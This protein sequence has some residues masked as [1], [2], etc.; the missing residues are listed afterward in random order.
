MLISLDNLSVVTALSAIFAVVT[1]LSAIVADTLSN[2][3]PSPSN[4]VAVTI[5]VVFMLT[6][7][8]ICVVPIAPFAILE[9][10]TAPAPSFGVSTALSAIFAVVTELSAIVADTLSNKLPSPSNAVAVTIPVVFML[11]S[12]AILGVITEPAA[13]LVDVIVSFPILAPVTA[14]SAIFAVVTELSAIV[15]DTLSNRLPSP[16]NAEAVTIPVV[17]MLIS[18]AILGVITEPAANLV[19]VIVSFPI[20]APV[21]ALSAIFAV[22]TELSAIVA[23]TLSNRLPSP[24]NAVAVTIP[25]VLMLISFAI[26]GVITEPAANLV[27][28]I[29]SFPILAPVTALSAIFA[30]VTEL[31]AIVAD[32][33]SNRLPSPSNAVAVTIPV[34]LMLISFAILGVITEPAANL[35]DVIVSFPILAPVTA[36]SAIFAVVTELSAIVADTL[37][38]RLPSP[39]NAV[40]VTIPVVLMLISFAILG[41]ITEPAANLVDV[42][43][44]FPILAPVTALSAIFAVVTELSAIVADTLSNRLPSP[45]NAVAVTIPV[46]LMLISFAI[47]GVITEPA[48]NLVDVI[49]SFPILAPVT[50]LSAIFAV[51]TELSAIVADTLS[52]R[53]PSPSNAVAVTI[54]VVLMLI[55]F[56]ILGVI[57]EPAANLVDV[58]VSFPILAPVTALSAIFAVVTELSAIVADTLS[59]RLPSPSNAVAVTIPV[60]LMLISFAILGV[61]TE[62]AANLVDVIVSFPILAPVTALS[63]IFAVVTELSAIVADTLSNRLPSPSNAVA[64]TIP[65]VLM[66]ISFAILGVITEP[67]ANL[68][69]V[70]VSFPILA[71]VT[72]LS[73]IFAVVT[74]LSAIV[75]DTLSNRLPSPSNAV[76]VTIPVVLMLIS[77]AILGVITEP[78][79]N[80]VD[81]IVS[82]PILAPV[83]ALSAIF[84]VVTELSAIVADTLS[85]RLPSPSNAVAVTIPVV[86][87]LISFA[88]L[89]VITEPAANLVDVI[90]SFPIL[91]PVTALSAIFAV[92]TELSAIVADTL[93]NRLPSP[94]NAVAVTIPVVLMLISFAI[95]GVITEPAANLVDVIVS[96]PILAPVTALSAIFAVVTEL[97]AIVADTLSNRL[98]S[99]S[100][101]VAVTI[102][103]VLMLISFAIL[104]VITEPAANLVDV[105]V[106][107]P[108]LAPVT[109]LSA[110]FAVVTELSAIVADT[111]SNRLPSPSNAVA[112]TIPVVLMLISFAILGVITEP[113]ANLVDV[114]VSFPILAPVTALSAIFAVVTELSAIVADTLSNRL[115]SPSNAVAVT[116][117]VVLMLISFAILGV[118][119]EPAANLVDVIVS[120][121]ILAPVTAL[122]AI[123]AVVTELSAIV[124]DTLSNRLPS[125]SNA[126]AVTI[127]V[128]LM[129]ISF[130][131][132]GVITEPAANLVDVIVSFPILAPVTALS[133]IFA[134]VTELSAIV[135]DTL[136]N[137]L[138]SPSNAVAVTIPVVLM[139]I[140]FA[141]LGVITEP[142]A[143]LVDVIVSFPILAPVTALS[144][145]F[146]VVTELSA[147]VAD[148]LSNRL[149]SPSNAVAV[150][151]PVVLMLISFAILGVITEPAANLV[152]VIVSFPILAP[153]TALSAIFAVVTELSA[154]V[155]DTLS[156][157]LPSPSNAVAVTI[158]VVLMLISFA[159]LGVITE[160]AAN[161]V[162]VIVS[163]PILAPVTALSAI[164]A[165]VTEL[166]AI[167][168]DTLSNRL[169]SPSNAEAVTIPVVFML[170]SFVICVVPIAPFAIFPLVIVPGITVT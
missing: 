153:V 138:P 92:V 160:P 136:S 113:A 37:S 83:T 94:S 26:L 78:A 90:V 152:D 165:V 22:V 125:P 148:T 35:V 49:V 47:L 72:A 65:V 77:F 17:L 168:A 163:F 84:A 140:S 141:I 31:S 19:D 40:A 3:L 6:S 157:R 52:N 85:N 13:N 107:F 33:L 12:F 69:D 142:A 59:N 54:P 135:A 61:I 108:I 147:I 10:V 102:P 21:T 29:V 119:T 134:V 56:A 45:S 4:A 53:L 126:V 75:A 63:A 100:N 133:A 38:N 43:V 28:V 18:F 97:S 2:K 162:D 159:I 120:F 89:G 131:I 20:L 154:I 110:I 41:V 127:P 70:I 170:T 66:L 36:L 130:A 149:P 74:E 124:A 34:V 1:A 15:A 146:A 164:F 93:S 129:L 71:P 121:P 44:S 46:V 123:F 5:P 109:A 55:S 80:L 106:S 76:A 116:I 48:A 166:S 73:A 111:L 155:A 16:S 58:I 143:N 81:V 27:D 57:T 50:A 158:P 115:P 139:L 114:I 105:I 79:A 82:F 86:L 144:A 11:I 161:L 156:N 99:P 169:P 132:L 112:V 122:S 39:S 14:L 51:V 167:V 23:D 42:I 7:F 137:R 68:V 101:A 87:M 30:V 8:V 151:I 145:I 150:T 103:V 67:A 117:P 128:V 64:V 88:I 32:T 95:L 104:G 118:I 60:V 98:P 25:V 62:P 9:P 91:A 24:S 96:F